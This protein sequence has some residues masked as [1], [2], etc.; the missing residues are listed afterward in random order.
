MLASIARNSVAIDPF[1]Q[2][3]SS[4]TTQSAPSSG[5]GQPSSSGFGQPAS[6][7]GQST[8]GFGQSNG[9][10]GQPSTGFGQP[11]PGFG[12]PAGGFGQ[13]TGGFGQPGG[14]GQTST[15]SFGNNPFGASQGGQRPAD[16]FG[17]LNSHGGDVMVPDNKQGESKQPSFGIVDLNNLG[18]K[19]VRTCS[20]FL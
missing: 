2:M 4:R 3:A 10:F 5:F 13:P 6:G 18:S 20:F 9:G 19:Q 1:A 12:Q 15:Q 7:F 14:F 16:P 8:G 11:A 17:D